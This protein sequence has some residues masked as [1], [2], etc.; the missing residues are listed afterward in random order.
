MNTSCGVRKNKKV[1][2]GH[3]NTILES[4]DLLPT[5]L[6]FTFNVSHHSHHTWGVIQKHWVLMLTSWWCDPL[7]VVIVLQEMHAAKSVTV[8]GVMWVCCGFLRD[9]VASHALF[10]AVAILVILLFPFS[11]ASH[12]C[13][14]NTNTG[15]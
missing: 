3:H 12:H 14:K 8:V 5:T 6:H 7:L 9:C 13:C 10:G 1:C 2:V 11:F 4:G 15:V